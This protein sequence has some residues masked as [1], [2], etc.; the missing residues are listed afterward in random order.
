MNIV[1]KTLVIINLLFA[2][3]TGGFLVVDFATRTN[4]KKAYELLEEETKVARANY[5]T[6]V[7]TAANA[8]KKE[9]D[10]AKLL[11]DTNKKVND[12]ETEKKALQDTWMIKLDE[13]KTSAKDADLKHQQ[14]AAEADRLKQEAKDLNDTIKK[15]DKFILEIQDEKARYLGEAK[16]NEQKARSTQDRNEA[17]L[18]EITR[19]Q[20][21][22]AEVDAGAGGDKKPRDPSQP[23]P[24]PVY[25]KGVIERIDPKD[26]TL[27]QITLGTDQGVNVNHTLE[28]FR[29]NPQPKYLGTIRIVEAFH[30]KAIARVVRGNL[31]E[32]RPPLQEGD[33]VASSLT[34]R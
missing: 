17:L 2:L 33:R 5:N 1:G 4:W 15:R 32:G 25:V 7:A 30:H 14:A 27:V 9:K 24:P 31:V 10:M 3:A 20:Q 29:F 8:D 26:R 23:N 11:E 12:L 18:A 16:A 13:A 28:V 6:L 34:P 22:I 19:L 21:K